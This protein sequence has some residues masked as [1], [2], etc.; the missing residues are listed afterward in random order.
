MSHMN[1]SLIGLANA[2]RELSVS[3]VENIT[4]NDFIINKTIN[5]VISNLAEIGRNGQRGKD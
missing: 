2:F 3:L 5:L 4:V 1:L